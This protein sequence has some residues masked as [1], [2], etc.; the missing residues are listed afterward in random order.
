VSQADEQDFNETSPIA[1]AYPPGRGFSVASADVAPCGGIDPG[2]RTPYPLGEP[3]SSSII[4][5]LTIVGGDV[6]FTQISNLSSVNVLYTNETDPRRFH[7]FSFYSNSLDALGAGH[8][9][10]KGPDFASLGFQSGDNATLLVIY[11][12]GGERQYYYQCADV[13]LVDVASYTAPDDYVCGN[14]TGLLQEASSEDSLGGGNSSS[15]GGGQG[16]SSNETTTGTET[17]TGSDAAN[18]DASAAGSSSSSDSGLSAAA[19]GG[20]GAA[21]TL[22]VVA[23][24]LAA[25]FFTGLFSFGKK[26][27]A[28]TGD[29]ASSSSGV[30]TMKQTRV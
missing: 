8:Y 14:Y 24:L 21:V 29:D 23:L 27:T 7:A 6:A 11:Q 4:A 15:Y 3:D 30:P 25:A 13:S 18:S 20:I 17:S 26:R 22:V 19:G 10:S 9:C 2:A 5:P 16:S 1:W 28:A 12:L